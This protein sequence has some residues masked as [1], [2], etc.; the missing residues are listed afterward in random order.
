MKTKAKILEDI[1]EANNKSTLK[2]SRRI[3]EL[4]K[5]VD[6]LLYNLAKAEGEINKL[7]K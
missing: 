7:N 1:I 2:M 4:E 3:Q 6:Y 5:M